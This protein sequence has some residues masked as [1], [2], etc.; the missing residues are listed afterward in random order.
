M[1]V[2]QSPFT[3]VAIAPMSPTVP[4]PYTRP[5]RSATIR[6]PSAT[7]AARYSGLDPAEEPQNTQMRLRGVGVLRVGLGVG[8][9]VE[10]GGVAMLENRRNR[11]F[12]ADRQERWREGGT[13]YSTGT[14]AILHE[15]ARSPFH[16]FIHTRLVRIRYPP[17]K[18]QGAPRQIPLCCARRTLPP[19]QMRFHS[20]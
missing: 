14:H 11:Y 13:K 19:F 16:T 8:L 20:H 15:V 17:E 10:S 5:M 18:R 2:P 7:A 3:V 12:E 4:P 1:Q 9:G 6:C